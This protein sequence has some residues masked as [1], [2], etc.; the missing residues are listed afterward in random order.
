MSCTTYDICKICA[1]LVKSA[2]VCSGAF[3]RSELGEE[4]SRSDNV[5]TSFEVTSFV[6][7]NHA[8]QSGLSPIRSVSACAPATARSWHL[9]AHKL[10]KKGD[11]T[12]K[13]HVHYD[14]SDVLAHYSAMRFGKFV[15][16]IRIT[17]VQTKTPQN[18]NST[19]V[20]HSW[21]LRAQLQQE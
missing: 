18:A 21:T 11:S 2:Q 10:T 6:I 20:T 19:A 3:W 12:K 7:S 15:P 4:Q 9:L 14:S 13:N 17:K 16:R 5:I 1:I 8:A